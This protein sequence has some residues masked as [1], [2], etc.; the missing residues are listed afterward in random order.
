[1][2]DCGT[3]D[4]PENPKVGVEFL[5]SSVKNWPKRTLHGTV[6][7]TQMHPGHTANYLHLSICPALQHNNRKVW[8]HVSGVPGSRMRAADQNMAQFRHSR[9]SLT[10]TRFQTPVQMA[11]Q[12]LIYIMN[13]SEPQISDNTQCFMRRGRDNTLQIAHSVGWWRY[14]RQINTLSTQNWPALTRIPYR[15]YMRVSNAMVSRTFMVLVFPQLYL[16]AASAATTTKTDPA[17][18]IKTASK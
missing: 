4:R 12:R 14:S 6:L 11:M 10:Q 8:M 2:R 16:Q 5:D 18:T 13:V 9:S 3:P 1:M 7:R 17:E 15:M